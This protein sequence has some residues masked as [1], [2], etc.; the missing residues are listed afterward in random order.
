MDAGGS[1]RSV[2]IRKPTRIYERRGSPAHRAVTSGLL[3]SYKQIMVR[4]RQP[5]WR[6]A[7]ALDQ[8]EPGSGLICTHRI[9]P[10]LPGGAERLHSRQRQL[11]KKRRQQLAE[12]GQGG[13][14]RIADGRSMLGIQVPAGKVLARE[15]A[16]QQVGAEA[17][18]GLAKLLGEKFFSVGD[19]CRPAEHV[20]QERQPVYSRRR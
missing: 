6:C 9:Q 20:A 4:A 10:L 13:E 19:F 7:G 15:A 2:D 5:L 12:L 16:V 17:P 14:V 3:P 1:P 8:V 18:L 11:L